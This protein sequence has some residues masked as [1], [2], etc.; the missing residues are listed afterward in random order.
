MTCL[1][2]VRIDRSGI[3]IDVLRSFYVAKFCS[4]DLDRR[5]AF[6]SLFSNFIADMFTLAVTISPYE[7]NSCISCLG[8]DILGNSRLVLGL[9]Q[10]LPFGPAGQL[11]LWTLT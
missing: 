4:L 2:N 3:D 6:Y 9:C 5:I 8:L 1:R 11:T 7:E 10:W